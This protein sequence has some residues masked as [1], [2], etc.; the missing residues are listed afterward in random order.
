MSVNRGLTAS[1]AVPHHSLA[2]AAT[3]VSHRKVLSGAS[4]KTH[5]PDDIISDSSPA[6]RIHFRR[7]LGGCD[8]PLAVLFHPHIH[9]PERL[10]LDDYV[11][12]PQDCVAIDVKLVFGLGL[13]AR[14]PCL[15][16]FEALAPGDDASGL[17]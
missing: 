15:E 8:L 3:T 1:P 16:L 17:V 13:G 5:Q 14:L 12:G 9:Y 2:A 11:P 10:A 7:D 4:H 6:R